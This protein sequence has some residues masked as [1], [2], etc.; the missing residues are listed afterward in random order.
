MH[1]LGRAD[2]VGSDRVLASQGRCCARKPECSL[3]DKKGDRRFLII[4]GY[5]QI[6][7]SGE[8]SCCIFCVCS[9]ACPLFGI[10]V[11][12]GSGGARRW[13]RASGRSRLKVRP[14]LQ[15]RRSASKLP[16]LLVAPKLVWNTG[17]GSTGFVFVTANGRQP[18]LVATGPEGSRVISWIRTGRYVFEL[19]GDAERRTL[20]AKVTVS[21]VAEPGAPPTYGIMARPSSAGCLLQ[22]SSRF[23]TS[24][25]TSARP[26]RAHEI[27]R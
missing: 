11:Y 9:L 17:N 5:A 12:A 2:Q 26:G 23:Y 16:K 4:I 24:R 27:S 19:Y 20:L 6:L 13:K 22:C 10:A 7:S 14:R 25:C 1:S 18:V 21:G 3:H 8:S 15:L